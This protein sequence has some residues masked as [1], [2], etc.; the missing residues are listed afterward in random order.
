MG[1]TR[2]QII[3]ASIAAAAFP[4][5]SHAQV[6]PVALRLVRRVGWQELMGRNL[7]VIGDLYHSDRTFPVSDL[8]AKLSNALE[9]PYRNNMS[10]ISSIPTGDYEGF[11]RSDGALGWRIELRGTGDRSHIQLHV[12]NR[13]SNSV[14]CILP[15]TGESSD[16]TCTI[17]G[18]QVAMSKLMGVVGSGVSRMIVLRIQT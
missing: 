16:A 6:V 11:V 12:G 17:D 2:R 4:S 7:C 3:A 8:G 9:L 14:G 1:V 18:S 13:P 5:F 10:Q 15:G